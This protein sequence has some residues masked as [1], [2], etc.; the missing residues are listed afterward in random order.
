[1]RDRIMLF[2]IMRFINRSEEMARLGRLVERSEGGLAVVY[3]RRRLG[4]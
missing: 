4:S 1:M 3:G 2:C